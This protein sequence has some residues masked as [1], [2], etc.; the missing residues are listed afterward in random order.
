VPKQTYIEFAEK[1]LD[2]GL[3]SSQELMVRCPFNDHS[4]YTMQFNVKT[5]LWVCF[6]CHEGGSIHK[7][8]KQLGVA[9]DFRKVEP[10]MKDV[11]AKL[12][13]LRSEEPRPDEVKKVLLDES[14]LDRFTFPTDYWGHHKKSCSKKCKDHRGFD[15]ETIDEYGFG[16]EFMDNYATIPLRTEQGDLLGVIKR[17]LDPDVE[18]RYRYPSFKKTGFKRGRELF[19]SWQLNEEPSDTAVIVEGSIDQASVWQAGF[20]SLAQYGSSLNPAQIHL[21]L[22]LGIQHAILF[23]D[24]DKAGDDAVQRA[25]GR[26]H[27]VRNN[28]THMEYD[29][30]LD[31]RR[32]GISVS[33][34]EYEYGM[35]SDPGSMTPDE[36]EDAVDSARHV[37]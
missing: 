24:D 23:F 6:S 14:Y 32:H 19:G 25:M 11:Y 5:G 26:V 33:I 13:A 27:H 2:I 10:D 9:G 28:R 29:S 12:R 34:V 17:Y 35:K 21:M 4:N 15:Q 36:I 7:L 3:R 20:P 18:L 8:A 37:L 31:L 16:Y 1:H 30:S 22:R